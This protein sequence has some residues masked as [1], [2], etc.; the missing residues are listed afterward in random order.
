MNSEPLR[1]LVFDLDDTLYLERDYVTSGF[2]AVARATATDDTQ[3]A[4]YAAW[5]ADLMSR[6]HDGRTFNHFL[7]AF[8]E[9]AKRFTVPK[10]VQLYR[11]HLPALHLTPEW[12]AA[13]REWREQN[14]FLGLVSDGEL[15]GQQRKIEALHLTRYFDHVILTDSY[16]KEH[17][18]PHLRAFEEMQNVSG[19][20]AQQLIYVGD[21]VLKDFNG[22]NTLGWRTLRLRVD[23]Q[24]RQALE[25]ATSLHAA[26]H[27]V[28]SI[29]MMK[30]LLSTLIEGR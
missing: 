16:G 19:L 22:P 15:I 10:L 23:G 28:Q 14:V 18:K 30:T 29:K 11:E 5:M 12:Q 27:E 24:V 1:G 8:P 3:A 25:P 26:Q 2:Q 4:Q 13:L 17:W 20:K 9:V 6:G 7:D 21:N